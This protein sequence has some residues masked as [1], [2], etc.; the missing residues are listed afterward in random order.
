MILNRKGR[1]E[2]REEVKKALLE[3]PQGQR[4]HLD[5]ELLEELLFET[6][7]ENI[8]TGYR[9]K[10]YNQEVDL[11]YLVWTGA[12]LEK[13][14][15]SEV[16]FSD[17]IWDVSFD[18]IDFFHAPSYEKSEYEE[19]YKI[20]LANTNAKIDF[21][22]SFEAKISPKKLFPHTPVIRGVE[23][24]GTNLSNNTLSN[25]KI[26]NCDFSNTLLGL[27]LE[28]DA[29]I[30]VDD[31]DLSGNSYDVQVPEAFF[32][33]DSNIRFIDTDLSDTDMEVLMGE[34]KV[35]ATNIGKCIR[36]G[37]LTNC[38]VNGIMILDPN[39]KMEV[40]EDKAKE[41]EAYKD[42]RIKTI[43]SSIRGQINSNQN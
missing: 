41:Y 37:Y 29:Q 21:E 34:D 16:D 2:L 27:N 39:G 17:V 24:W 18:P 8:D 30:I 14:D 36:K 40:K 4:V 10:Y 28:T 11:K 38:M 19:G 13:V 35:A 23:A 20:Y 33:T 22:Q 32:G 12:F 3:V 9:L 31:S 42:Q 1:D 5:K 43:V 15:L 26:I 25:V 6:H 7:H